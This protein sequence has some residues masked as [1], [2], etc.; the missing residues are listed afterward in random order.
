MKKTMKRTV[1][2]AAVVASAFLLVTGCQKKE[3]NAPAQSTEQTTQGAEET[4]EESK[5]EETTK[6]ETPAGE[7]DLEEIH[8]AVKEAYGEAYVPSMAFDAQGMKDVFGI[9]S[10]LYENFIAEGPMMST[11]VDQFVA[12]QAKEGKGEEV[13]A[14]LKDYQD[15][16]INDS[17]QYP[18]NMAK[19]K[20]SEVIRHE[21][22]VFFLM[23]GGYD[24]SGA[25]TEDEA[26]ALEAAK[27]ANKIGVDVINGFFAS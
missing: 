24:D 9:S 13:E 5:T 14:L 27:E 15:Y 22:Y 26:A 16:L 19:I 11:H 18:M 21:D 4:T 10:D 6:A 1:A 2:T 12:I 23:L 17:M 20:A 3:D 7:V 25:E 8:T